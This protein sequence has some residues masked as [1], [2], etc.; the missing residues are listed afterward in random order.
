MGGYAGVQADGGVSAGGR[1]AVLARARVRGG[2]RAR[3]H[4]QPA[5]VLGRARA[6]ARLP[7]RQVRR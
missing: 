3:R 6:R 2:V 1:G 5:P 7:R 4:A